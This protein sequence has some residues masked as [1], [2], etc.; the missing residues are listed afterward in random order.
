MSTETN[1]LLY[2][3]RRWLL[4]VSFL[5]GVGMVTLAR[6]GDT[7][8]R[9]DVIFISGGIFGFTCTRRRDTVVTDWSF[10]LSERRGS[11]SNCGVTKPALTSPT[12]N[13]TDLR[14]RF[15]KTVFCPLRTLMTVKE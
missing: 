5:L 13:A 6:I 14:V 7:G 1:D 15:C 9:G 8:G 3:I 4:A 11:V 2:S 10:L 12:A